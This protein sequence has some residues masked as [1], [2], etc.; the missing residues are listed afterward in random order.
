[1][2]RGLPDYKYQMTPGLSRLSYLDGFTEVELINACRSN[3]PSEFADLSEF[4][5]LAKMQ[6][7]GLP[8]RLLD[9]TLNPLVA[10]YFACESKKSVNGRVLCHAS[11]LMSDSSQ[12]IKAV[13]ETVMNRYVDYNYSINEYVCSDYLSPRQYMAAIYLHHDTKVV[14][15]KYWNQRI[16]NQEGVFMVFPN[17]HHDKYIHILAHAEKVGIDAAI[18]DYGH[19]NVDR[20]DIEKAMEYEPIELYAKEYKGY[21]TDKIYKELIDSY[22]GTNEEE[23][24]WNSLGDRIL[25][26]ED[27]KQ[28]DQDKISKDFCSIL[29]NHTDKDRILKSLSQIGIREDYIYPELEYTAKEVRRQYERTCIR[30]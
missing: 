23:N 1:M 3:K 9:F 26:G 13:C 5:V 8:T 12:F 22:A 18:R 4:D 25:M 16:V 27:L 6:H 24:F 21:Y 20:K 28:I 11:F 29:I 14:R 30:Y 17:N 2:F 7:Y 15:P 19:N 10:L